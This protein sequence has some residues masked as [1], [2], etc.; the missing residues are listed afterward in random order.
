MRTTKISDVITGD[1]ALYTNDFSIE[2]NLVNYIIFK[3]NKM[4]LMYDRN[5]RNEVKN[6]IFSGVSKINGLEYSCC[7]E[8]NLYAKYM[9]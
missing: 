2:S 3:E 7:Y 5:Y 4:S 1:C 6:R 8:L 9:N